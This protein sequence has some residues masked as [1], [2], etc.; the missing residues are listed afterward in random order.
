MVFLAEE[1]G[2]VPEG[3]EYVESAV[4]TTRKN[5]EMCA[6]SS[7]VVHAGDFLTTVL[8]KDYDLVFSL[9]F[10]EH[11]AD[12]DDVIRRMMALLKD[13]GYLVIGLPKLTGLNYFLARVVDRTLDR[14]L[15]PAH[16]LAIMYRNYFLCLPE[17]FPL[18]PVF[19]NYIGG[20]EP[21]LFDISRTPLWF[22]PVFQALSIGLGNPIAR[23]VSPG[24][25]S[26]YIMA[27]YRKEAAAP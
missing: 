13:H 12:P 1:L 10:I 9:G 27:I 21:A 17:R 11:F 19:V 16:N 18:V 7:G 4:A 20:F 24:W 26:G 15:L 5:L 8:G 3:C 22:K 6:I 23:R 25:W 2:Y 14:P